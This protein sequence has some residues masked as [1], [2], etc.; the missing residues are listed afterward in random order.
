MT[1]EQNPAS[2]P[3]ERRCAV[4]GDRLIIE[5]GGPDKPTIYGRTYCPTCQQRLNEAL[6]AIEAR[7]GN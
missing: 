5:P 4:H 1:P 3:D 2:V 6:D 7:R